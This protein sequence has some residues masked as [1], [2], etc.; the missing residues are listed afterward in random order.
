MGTVDVL[1]GFP[2]VNADGL[3]DAFPLRGPMV[4]QAETITKIAKILI[5]L[6]RRIHLP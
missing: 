5:N 3:A 6:M 1:S 4:L 2:E